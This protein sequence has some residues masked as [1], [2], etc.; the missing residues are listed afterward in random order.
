MG[1]NGKRGT[2]DATKSDMRHRRDKTNRTP[3]KVQITI[4]QKK[5]K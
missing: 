5:K 4:W 1:Q 3:E 2:L